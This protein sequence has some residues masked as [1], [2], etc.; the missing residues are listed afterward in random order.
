MASEDEVQNA[1]NIFKEEQADLALLH[2]VSS[3]PLKPE[4]ANLGA[5]S[6]LKK[7]FDVPGLF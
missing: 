7:K 3:Y 6:T 5:I 4:N 2:C 1:V